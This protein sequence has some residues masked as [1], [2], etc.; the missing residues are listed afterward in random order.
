[1]REDKMV[2]WH[3]RSM[4]MSLIKLQETVKDRE[5]WRAEV[6]GV[7]KNWEQL[8]NVTTTT[9]KYLLYTTCNRDP[10]YITP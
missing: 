4:D 3:H 10:Y 6:H 8:S 9:N 1:M 5:A 2:G 7:A